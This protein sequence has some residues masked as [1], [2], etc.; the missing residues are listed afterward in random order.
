MVRHDIFLFALA[1]LGLGLGVSAA[2]AQDVE[3]KAATRAIENADP[4][5]V[6]PNLIKGEKW[7]LDFHFEQPEPI[8]VGDPAT[9]DR[10]VFWYVVYTATNRTG[11]DRSFVPVFTLYAD[12]GAIR[13]AGIYPTVFDAIKRTRKVRFLENAVQVIGKILVGDDNART[14]VAI[15]PPLDRETARFTIFVEG[16]SGEYVERPAAAPAAKAAE[17]GKAA[18]VVRLRKTLAIAYSL[19]GDRWWRNLDQPIF[20]SKKWTWR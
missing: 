9:G 8:V 4:D 13:R 18:E 17:T 1:A 7:T 10:Q 15:F 14:G 12:T 3:S 11:A 20:V 6:D 16:L 2:G 19:P 5:A